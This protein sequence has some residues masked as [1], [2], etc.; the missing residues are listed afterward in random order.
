[1]RI[2]TRDRSFYRS[3]FRLSGAIVLQNL[4][5]YSVNLADNVMIGRYAEAALNGVS[6]ANQLQFLLQMFAGGIAAGI[7]VIA[8]QYWGQRRVEPIRRI[9]SVGLT[10]GLIGSAALTA[11][12]VITPGGLLGILTNSPK[13]IAE[14][15]KYVR[16]VAAS[17]C[18]FTVSQILLGALRSVE[19]VR[20]GFWVSVV[21]LVINVSLN[22]I[23][24]FPTFGT[25]ELGIRGAA[26]ATLVSRIAEL[27]LIIVYLVFFD[28]KLR[29]KFSEVFLLQKSYVRDF[30]K[31]GLPLVLSNV[32]WGLA[33]S[34]QTAIIGRLGDEVISANSIAATV[35]QIV[36]VVIYGTAAATSVVIGKAVGAG[37]TE[38]AKEYARTL[39]L[40]YVVLGILS[41]AVLFAAKGPVISL[42]SSISDESARMANSFILVLCVTIVGTAYQMSCLTGIVSGGGQTGFVFVNDLIFMWG[43]VLPASLLAA[44][45]LELSP[46]AVFIC[47]KSD[48]ILKCAVAVVKVNRFTWI[49]QLTR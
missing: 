12:A 25:P 47:L 8:A 10:L 27:A 43:I 44:F 48:Q 15:A 41:S 32:S 22:Y 46:L 31:S 37:K 14:G 9:V 3:L 39:Q 6:I 19:T 21:S 40:I 23:L 35:F 1:M 30:L 33:M 36:S 2:I 17:Y 29:L 28:K 20:I 11:A 18:F 16:I 38:E 13:V 34:I 26:I 5:T 49:R 45:V 7:S 24:I 4:I 42:Y